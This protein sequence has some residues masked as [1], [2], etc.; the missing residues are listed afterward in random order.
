MGKYSH[1]GLA[2]GTH[3]SPQIAIDEDIYSMKVLEIANRLQLT[4]NQ[5]IKDLIGKSTKKEYCS[6]IQNNI[7]DKIIS[8]IL[9]MGFRE[10]NIDNTIMYQKNNIILKI[11]YI[12]E[13]GYYVL[14]KADN[15]TD[16]K[17]NIFE[18]LVSISNEVK[19][20]IIIKTIKNVL[21]RL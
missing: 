16:A 4:I 6:E 3:G 19:S 1:T 9:I 14:D 20:N 2:H 7:I 21:K 17:N 10:I 15:I 5:D 18:L 11:T 8:L 12:E 13:Y